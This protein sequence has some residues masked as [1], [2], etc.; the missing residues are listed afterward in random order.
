MKRKTI[1]K[2]LILL[3]LVCMFILILPYF[4]F[5]RPTVFPWFS[6]EAKKALP[7]SA[8]EFHHFLSRS[9]LDYTY[10]L[11]AK[12]AQEDVETYRL[13]LGLIRRDPEHWGERSNWAV[14]YEDFCPW[15]DPSPNW[16]NTFYDPNNVRGQ[17]RMMKYEDGYIYYVNEKL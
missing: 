14:Q 9:G 11:K 16:G 2:F 7:E 8:S 10:L 15:W 1:T 3:V 5:P 4:F 6:T 12:I 13:R 17:T